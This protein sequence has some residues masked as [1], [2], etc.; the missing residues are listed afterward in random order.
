MA[1]PARRD[2]DDPGERDWAEI[3]QLIAITLQAVPAAVAG[4]A[5]SGCDAASPA[6]DMLDLVLGVLRHL[7]ETVRRADIGAD[8]AAEVIA[9]A[10]EQDRAQRPRP[11]GYP[12]RAVLAAAPQPDEPERLAED[13]AAQLQ[14]PVVDGHARASLASSSSSV[15]PWVSSPDSRSPGAGFQA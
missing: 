2:A 14:L 7:D 9:R 13:Q 10:V 1:G 12:L 5:A 3:R 11:R 15:R 8:V 6:A 4:C